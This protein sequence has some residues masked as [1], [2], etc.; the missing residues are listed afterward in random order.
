MRPCW[1]GELGS[2]LPG[3]H[4]RGGVEKWP[5]TIGAGR[6]TC[7][8]AAV[9]PLIPVGGL[10]RFLHRST[11]GFGMRLESLCGTPLGEFPDQGTAQYRPGSVAD[12][13]SFQ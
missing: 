11:P 12:R 2:P 6:Q 10:L 9:H 1:Q 8:G 4:G 13:R 3:G 7:P 5:G